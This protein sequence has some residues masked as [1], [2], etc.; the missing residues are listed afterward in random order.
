MIFTGLIEVHGNRQFQNLVL[1]AS[2]VHTSLNEHVVTVN[3][4]LITPPLSNKLPPL[5]KPHFSGEES[6]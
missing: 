6:K 2:F 4:L 5:Y 1:A 3:P